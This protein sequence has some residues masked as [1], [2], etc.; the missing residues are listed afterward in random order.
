[1][2]KI[3]LNNKTYPIPDSALAGPTADFVAH[4]GTIAGSGLKVVIG[5]VEYGIDSSK[6]AD[7]IS[8]LDTL[9][10]SLH[11]ESSMAPGLYQTGAIALYEEQGAE[12]IE[13]MMVASW[14]DL[15]AD[16]IVH[17]EDG[18][19][20]TNFNDDEWENSSSDA[21]SGD[22]ILPNDGSVTVIGDFVYDDWEGR[23]AFMLCYNLTGVKIPDSVVTI[24]DGAFYECKALTK[25]SFY[26]D[27]GLVS[28]GNGVFEWCEN[29]TD[30]VIPNNV[31]TIGNNAFGACTNLANLT[32]SDGITTIGEYAFNY[33]GLTEIIIP[34]GVTEIRNS[35]FEGCGAL[36]SV[37]MSDSVTSIGEKAIY[38]CNSLTS[39]TIPNSVKSIGLL[40]FAY[41]NSLASIMY[42][43]TTVQW[44]EIAKEYGWNNSIPATHVQCSD[45]Q[46]AL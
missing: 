33:S 26:D 7:A 20:Y 16:G 5:G 27:S 44:D 10:G 28:I 19:L 36:V 46:V 31:L 43:G 18:L 37:T 41:N 30:V 14:D 22:L 1:M 17:V 12:A 25:V 11:S 38:Q 34:V 24:A 29:L 32:L 39:L 3:K 2:A 35:V 6:V 42:E 40:A 9:F 15:L 4:L 13:G 23:P 45:G 21:L 8:G